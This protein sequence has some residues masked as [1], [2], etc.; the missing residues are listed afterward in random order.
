MFGEEEI[1]A[2]L[3]LTW[4][5]RRPRTPG[6]A[7]AAGGLVEGRLPGDVAA[8]LKIDGFPI[9]KRLTEVFLSGGP[10]GRSV[11]RG[12]LGRGPS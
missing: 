12:I 7:W 10:G 4:P 8:S 1:L 5:G 6:G 3:D 11:R 2:D 9:E